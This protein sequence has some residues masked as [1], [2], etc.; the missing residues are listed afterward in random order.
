MYILLRPCDIL[1]MS[2]TFIHIFNYNNYA[3]NM[4]I[5]VTY[6]TRSSVTLLSV[7]KKMECTLPSENTRPYKL[8]IIPFEFDIKYVYAM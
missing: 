7:I 1:L 3:L 2:I 4:Y 8:I 6:M 5:Y